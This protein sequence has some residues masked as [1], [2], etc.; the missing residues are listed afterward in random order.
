[1]SIDAPISRRMRGQ[2]ESYPD[3]LESHFISSDSVSAL[4]REVGLWSSVAGQ[5]S[6]I[7]RWQDPVRIGLI[8][9]LPPSAHDVVSVHAAFLSAA[10]EHAVNVIRTGNNVEGNLGILC[11]HDPIREITESYW[12]NIS[13]LFDHDRR[14]ALRFAERV[15]RAG[16]GLVQVHLQLNGS[17]VA[18]G[19]IAVPANVRPLELYGLLAPSLIRV[20]GLLGSFS[21]FAHSVLA[22]SGST[23]EPTLLDRLMLAIHYSRSLT[24]GMEE[25]ALAASLGTIIAQ[26][27]SWG[28]FDGLA[29]LI[30]RGR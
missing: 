15:V 22:A 28:G 10:T 1:M 16:V 19:L 4:Y 2:P 6:R 23:Q 27:R 3:L 29:S 5:P 21:S 14:A 9:V 7:H 12:N 17:V 18:G 30:N 26:Q 20:M 11:L 8:G 24:P 25:G 13:S